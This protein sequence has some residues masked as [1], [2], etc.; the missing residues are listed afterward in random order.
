MSGKPKLTVV[1]DIVSIKVGSKEIFL[2]RNDQEEVYFQLGI[3]MFEHDMED[4]DLGDIDDW[5]DPL[6]GIDF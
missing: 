6:E 5:F 4:N 1:G 3:I 2:N